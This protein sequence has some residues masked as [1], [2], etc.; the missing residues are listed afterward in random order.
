MAVSTFTE[1]ET[2]KDNKKHNKQWLFS[3]T[4]LGQEAKHSENLK[5]PLGLNFHFCLSVVLLWRD[6]MIT[7]TLKTEDI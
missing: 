4:V 7:S 6:T 3:T 5:R 2:G 1:G